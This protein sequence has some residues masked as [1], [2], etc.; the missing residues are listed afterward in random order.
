MDGRELLKE[1]PE[2][3]RAGAETILS[4]PAWGVVAR[5]GETRL[6]VTTLAD[7]LADPLVLDV[8]L[9]GEPHRLAIADSPAFPDLHRL[10]A[11]RAGLPEALVLALVEKECGGLFLLIE[12]LTRKLFGL[13]G[14]AT[15]AEGLRP[16]A[17]AGAG[18]SLTFS[19]DLS[20]ELVNE[21]GRI[22]NLDP[23]HESIRALTRPARAVH[24]LVLLTDEELAALQPG[25]FVML[26]EDFGGTAK[27]ETVEALAASEAIAVV[28][29]QAAELSFAALADEAYPPLPELTHAEL[30]RGG[31]TLF[32]VTL[33]RVGEAKGLRLEPCGDVDVATPKLVAA[34]KLDADQSNN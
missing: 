11:A 10:W 15:S 22:E 23:A 1:W 5:A 13:K 19:L 6:K 24:G 17:A 4:M 27:W 29:P 26:P 12:S 33:A 28:E 25:D 7:Q 31:R 20:P 2:L 32:A 16:F 30:V 18:A 3:Q 14:L 9:D 34:P 8:T 21:L